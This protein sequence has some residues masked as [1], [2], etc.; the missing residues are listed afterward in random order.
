MFVLQDSF[1][2]HPDAIDNTLEATK[3]N[4]VECPLLMITLK[5]VN[6]R[7][8]DLSIFLMIAFG[9]SGHDGVRASE[10][11][12]SHWT[13]ARADQATFPGTY[14]GEPCSRSGC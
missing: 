5:L 4:N 10:L 13:F 1:D 7:L 9:H 11:A 2:G 6:M 12:K 3:S 8:I 14:C